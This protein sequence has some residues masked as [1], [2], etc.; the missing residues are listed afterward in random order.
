MRLIT[1]ADDELYGLVSVAAKLGRA[2][3][4]LDRLG[5]ARLASPD[6]PEAAFAHALARMAT[7]PS[8]QVGF[9]AHAEF[10]EVID[11]FGQV[12]DREPRHWLARYGRAR[13]RALIPSSYGA[14]TV[15][16]S[17]ELTHAAGDLDLLREHQAGVAS[18]PY[19]ASCHALAVVVDQLSGRLP[20]LSALRACAPVPVGLPALGAILC[21]PLVTLHAAGVGPEV[22]E[23]LRGLYGDQPAVARVGA[24]A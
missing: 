9:E 2:D 3:K 5:E 22:G 12:L 15:Q 18:Q 17:S 19:F 20:D 8:I 13:L 24:G 10:T 7:L 21:E 6:D 11:A 16:V 4:V 14:F 1:R 23:L